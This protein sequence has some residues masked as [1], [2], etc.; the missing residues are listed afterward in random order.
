[1]ALLLVAVMSARVV[2]GTSDALHRPRYDKLAIAQLDLRLNG[3]EDTRARLLI[4]E[5]VDAARRQPGLA[6][7]AVCN[8]S[9][10][11]FDTP[12]FVGTLD[13]ATGA[14]SRHTITGLSAVALGFLETLG[15]P[16]VRGRAFTDRDTAA[17]PHVTIVT[18]QLARDVFRTT[19]VVGRELRVGT[20][21]DPRAVLEVMTIVGVA[22]TS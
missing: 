21:A 15:V 16:I 2:I 12:A 18:E 13:D 7:V 4:D 1:V 19:D 6:G 20:S 14:R 11:V 17:A 10:D 5:L 22:A 3:V 8:G 9:P